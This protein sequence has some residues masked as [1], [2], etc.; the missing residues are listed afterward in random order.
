M[1]ACSFANKLRYAL[2]VIHTNVLRLYGVTYSP[3]ATESHNSS[4]YLVSEHTSKGSLRDVLQN[5]KYR[6]DDN[7]L[8]SMS[9]D[10]ASGMNFLHSQVRKEN[11]LLIF[12]S[13]INRPGPHEMLRH[14]T[15]DF[16][17][18]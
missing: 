5:G 1:K 2:Q 17:Q 3:L 8:Y 14:H 15:V 6:L 12:C 11:D 9:Y 13:I 18:D 10:V 16:L 7:F 4:L